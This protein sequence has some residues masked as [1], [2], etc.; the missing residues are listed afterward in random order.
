MGF[1]GMEGSHGGRSCWSRI[2]EW[3]RCKQIVSRTV[4][5]SSAGDG[6][7]GRLRIVADNVQKRL[8]LC[9]QG[10]RDGGGGATATSGAS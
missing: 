6:S 5:G 8:H 1:L 7:Q 2:D 10:L 4:E 9:L 3:E